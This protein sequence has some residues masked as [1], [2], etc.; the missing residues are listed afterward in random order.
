[1]DRRTKDVVDE[2]ISH[3]GINPAVL[4]EN[5]LVRRSVR[6]FKAITFPPRGI[7]SFFIFSADYISSKS[8]LSFLPITAIACLAQLK[9]SNEIFLINVAACFNDLLLLAN[10]SNADA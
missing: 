9:Q 4:N 6:T 8:F 7:N 2:V 5:P 1:M 10:C 3:K